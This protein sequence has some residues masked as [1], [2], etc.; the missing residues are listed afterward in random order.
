MFF[1]RT[2]FQVSFDFSLLPDGNL[3]LFQLFFPFF[4]SNYTVR[5]TLHILEV[6]VFVLIGWRREAVE[7][8]S[9]QLSS[10]ESTCGRAE[11]WLRSLQ[12]DKNTHTH[13]VWAT[14]SIAVIDFLF[15]DV[16]I[17]ESKHS[18]GAERTQR[19]EQQGIS[20][21]SGDGGFW[22][23][24]LQL[25]QRLLL[26]VCQAVSTERMPHQIL[27]PFALIAAWR[28]LSTVNLKKIQQGIYDIWKVV[29]GANR[30]PPWCS[31]WLHTYITTQ[32]RT[33]WHPASCLSHVVRC[34]GSAFF[35]P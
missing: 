26:P 11:C 27:T 3:N 19:M 17:F 31:V 33:L 15:F 34:R 14:I 16:E 12:S 1:L 5:T 30:C 21:F 28:G 32:I 24:Q 20:S 25:L 22:P 10:I 35:P 29:L 7:S 23:S 9:W 6:S 4:W 13:T 18:A 8:F 2:I